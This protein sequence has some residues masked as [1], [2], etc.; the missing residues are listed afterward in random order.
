MYF[1][2]ENYCVI[3]TEGGLEF[4]YVFAQ[5]LIVENHGIPMDQWYGMKVM[6]RACMDTPDRGRFGVRWKALSV[7]M[8]TELPRGILH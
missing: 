1:V 6:F 7:Q 5:N 4:G 8:I 3:I 2:R